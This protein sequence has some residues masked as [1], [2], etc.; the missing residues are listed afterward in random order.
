[1][2]TRNAESMGAYGADWTLRGY[3]GRG[4]VGSLL[5][6]IKSRPAVICG[7]AVTV[8][9]DLGRALSILDNPVVFGVNDVGMY[10]PKMDHWVSLHSDS[11]RTWRDVRWM[12]LT[13]SEDVKIHS[14]MQKPYINYAWEQITPCFALSGYFAMQIAWLMGASPIVL[15]GC[16]G[17]QMR[18]FFEMEARADFGYGSG[19]PGGNI[20][21]ENGV[22]EQLTREMDRVPEFRES[23]FS[24]S[25]WTRA[26]F[27]GIVALQNF[28]GKNH[29][30]A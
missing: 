20:A 11:L 27:G 2:T 12:R 9:R 15:A 7:N 3:A 24:M 21:S 8:W 25:G 22:R 26:Y 18:R 17:M 1:M 4:N 29:R 5:D 16:P 14:D 23:V 30:H 10:L 6:S 19:V 28:L 13:Q